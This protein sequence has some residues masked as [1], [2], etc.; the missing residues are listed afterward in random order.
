MIFRSLILWSLLLSIVS[1]QYPSEPLWSEKVNVVILK[2]DYE[3]TVKDGF[4]GKFKVDRAIK[5]Y[6]ENGKS[7]GNFTL[8]EN[9]YIKIKNI[10]GKIVD[11]SGK[12]LKKLDDDNII[13]ANVSPGFILYDDSKLQRIEWE[14]H[15][16]PYIVEYKYELELAS[17][18]FWNDWYPQNEVP[19][20]ESSYTLKYDSP[21]E[22]HQ[23]A[24]GID[25]EPQ[26]TSE[27]KHVVQKWTL[28][29]IEPL[30]EEDWMP[31]ESRVQMA[32]LFTPSQFKLDNYSG[33]FD[34]WTDFGKWSAGLYD[35][36]FELTPEVSEQIKQM[37]AN[38][39]SDREKID[40]LYKYLQNST[41]YVAI[42]LG[43]GGL[44][45]HPASSVCLNKYGDCKDLTT[46]M[47]SMA[48]EAGIEAYPVLVKTRNEGVVY[49]DFPSDQFN[50]VIC[51]V[52]LR[53][54]SLWLECT[55]D[56]LEAGD[57][58]PD[59]EGCFVLILNP[60]GGKLVQTPV[61]GPDK[62]KV[63][64]R[65]EGS[66]LND[67]S[68]LFSGKLDY[69]GNSAF[70]RRNDLSGQ[71]P[72]KITE[73]VTSNVIG[74]YAPKLILNNCQFRNRNE[75]FELPLITTFDGTIEK[76][77]VVSQNRIFFNPALLHRETARDIPK[78]K[79]R[80]F[81]IN[82][83]YPF[84]LADTF[85][86]SLPSGYEL[87]AAPDRQDISASFGRY[88]MDY[89]ISGQTLEYRRIMTIDKKLIP[90][91]SYQEY[92]EFIKTAAR[93]DKSKFVLIKNN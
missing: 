80:K 54:D 56:N 35:G 16:F 86:I 71:R 63:S 20:L 55:S 36:R 74:K 92:L 22:Y 60:Q 91:E 43:I 12:T 29:N 13:K 57:L 10:S 14:Y 69:E 18:Y 44:Q 41:R 1:A 3:M 90:P 58:P 7:Y 70:S 37:I 93:T 11:K 68:L 49:A 17:L 85:Q 67:A 66:L 79:E 84:M 34:S 26:I 42:S 52:P 21:F 25:T 64:S 72:E 87:E 27:G 82:Y 77:A 46:M 30:E 78:E 23:Y 50:H 83:G 28:R 89:Q 40:I 45:P 6:N 53:N 5:I 9:K 38:A 39:K 2:N 76:F 8:Y 59:D 75:N 61:S 73:W 15:T 32:L 24:I 65:I 88:V 51:L 19:V 62:N 33:N 4:S 31:R 47:I 81:P 48:R